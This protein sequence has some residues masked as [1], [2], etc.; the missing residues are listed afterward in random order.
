MSTVR[1]DV[2][3]H[4]KTTLDGM[5]PAAGYRT[6][7]KAGYPVLPENPPAQFPAWCIVEGR[8]AIE[9][10]AYPALNWRMT[11]ELHGLARLSPVPG[12]NVREVADGM[13]TDLV[14]AALTDSTRG[15]HAID[16]TVVSVERMAE[17]S[18][19]VWVVVTIE[20]LYRTSLTEPA[21]GL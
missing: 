6:A 20:I 9:V 13:I 16:T 12:V 7:W 14:R 3:D 17:V 19:D 5:T 10:V 18:P 4:L 8:E 11:V 21:S 2:L 15:G 1:G